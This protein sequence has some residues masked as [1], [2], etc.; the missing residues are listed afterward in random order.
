M[1]CEPEEAAPV[2]LNMTPM[3]DVVFQL[4][5]FFLCS[6]E[7]KSLDWKMETLLPKER[8]VAEDEVRPP[9]VPRLTFVLRGD[10]G[11]GTLVKSGGTVVGRLRRGADGTAAAIA[12][13]ATI[14][15]LRDI[16]E[17]AFARVGGM[18]AAANAGFICELDA[19]PH[20]PAG[21]VLLVADALAAVLAAAITF[22]GTPEPAR[23]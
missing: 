21:D 9:E 20:V 22:S 4:I 19:G 6:M 18:R 11:A 2:R 17:A 8:W 12:T 1:P 16:A 5:V 15:G 13:S 7:F 3:I 10:A 23:R 14:T